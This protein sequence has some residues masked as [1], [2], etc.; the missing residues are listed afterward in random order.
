MRRFWTVSAA[1]VAALAM[2]GAG[3]VFPAQAAE[4]TKPTQTLNV[5]YATRTGDFL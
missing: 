4:N 3:F 2:S 5:D 1:A